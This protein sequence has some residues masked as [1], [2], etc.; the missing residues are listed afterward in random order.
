MEKEK[1]AIERFL[2]RDNLSLFHFSKQLQL[3]D[4]SP[5]LLVAHSSKR[6][7]SGDHAGSLLNQQ[8]HLVFEKTF[9]DKS[10][11]IL[12]EYQL[13]VNINQSQNVDT[14]IKEEVQLSKPR[15]E[16]DDDDDDDDD[17]ESLPLPPSQYSNNIIEL[18]DS[19]LQVPPSR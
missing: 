16:E 19:V 9:P 6:G 4:H 12:E 8:Q 14:I 1:E 17:V 11:G 7:R 18:S 13:E 15:H 5:L 3:S 10:H 2:E